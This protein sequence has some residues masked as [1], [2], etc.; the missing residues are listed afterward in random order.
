MKES[1]ANWGQITL[2]VSVEGSVFLRAMRFLHQEMKY[3]ETFWNID[4]Y[5]FTAT[6]ARS[7]LDNVVLCIVCLKECGNVTLSKS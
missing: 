1:S 5:I 6:I 3:F 7:L 2:E 4:D